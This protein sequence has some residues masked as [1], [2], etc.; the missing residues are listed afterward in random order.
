MR[1]IKAV[2]FDLDGVLI[3][4][5]AQYTRIWADIDYAFPT[6]VPDLPHVIK[7]TT[8]PS[9]LSTYFRAED[10]SA[11][12]AMLRDNE[13]RMVYEYC[14]GAEELLHKLRSAGVRTVIVTSSKKEKMANVWR[15]LP[16]LRGL[17]D[18]VVDADSVTRSKPDP[19]GYLLGADA[20]GVT[21]QQCVVVEDSLQGITA[22]KRAGCKIIG[23]TGTFGRPAIEQSEADVVLD[24]LEEFKVENLKSRVKS[25]ELQER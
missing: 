14:L 17:V 6:G 8:L 2:L 22:G 25:R 19:Q 9:I 4:S 24:S 5:E 23:L 10:H 21:P 18:A 13:R 7:G 15:Q 20:V 12:T 3:D 1:D 11:I 16:G